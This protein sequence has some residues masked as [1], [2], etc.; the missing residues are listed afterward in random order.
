MKT[1]QIPLD[2]A[3]VLQEISEVGEED[4]VTLSDTLRLSKDR[5][6]HIIKSLKNKGLVRIR[7]TA[8]DTWVAMSKKGDKLMA[9]I[10]PQSQIALVS[11]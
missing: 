4:I 5:L 9:E 8:Q 6:L 1:K 10:W 7:N 11:Y 3:L 2:Y